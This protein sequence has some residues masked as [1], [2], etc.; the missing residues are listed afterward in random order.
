[1]FNETYNSFR[2]GKE[3]KNSGIG[4]SKLLFCNSLQLKQKRKKK[5][6]KNII[7][8]EK[9]IKYIPFIYKDFPL[10]THIV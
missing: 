9:D 3:P 5:K 1:V 4:P 8:E 2:F 7:L 10:N 6:E